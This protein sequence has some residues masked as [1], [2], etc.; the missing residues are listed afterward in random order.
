[1]HYDINWDIFEPK[2]EIERQSRPNEPTQM[3]YE[4]LNNFYGVGKG[5]TQFK[6][7][8]VGKEQKIVDDIDGMTRLKK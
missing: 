3:D 6:V 1:M 4:N 5:K 7:V 8:I 2:I